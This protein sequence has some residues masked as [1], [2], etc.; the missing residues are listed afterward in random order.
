[1]YLL[2]FLGFSNKIN[3]FDHIVLI[4]LFGFCQQDE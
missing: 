4:E 2:G 3:G 1:M